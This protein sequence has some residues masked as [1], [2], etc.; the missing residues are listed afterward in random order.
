METLRFEDCRA[1][2]AASPLPVWVLDPEIPAFHWANDAALELWRATSVE[3]LRARDI[4]SQAPPKVTAR[5]ASAVSR[6]R[7]G[8]RIREEWVFYPKGEPVVMTLELR[9]ITL[10]DERFAVLNYALPM[11]ELT[12]E[13]QR[14]ITM[15]RHLA[16]VCALVSATGEVLSCNPAAQECFEDTKAW[17]PWFVEPALGEQLLRDALAEGPAEVLA[18]VETK[19]GRRW[20]AIQ[21]QHLR[22][23]VTG[24]ISVLVEHRDETERIEVQRLAADRGLHIDEL[25]TALDLVEAQRAEI[26]ELSAPILDV[27]NGTLAVPIIGRFE[28]AQRDAL[29]ERLLTAAAARSIRRVILD[30]TGVV[31]IDD[32]SARGLEALVRALRLLGTEP[33]VTGVRASLA[34]TLVDSR[35]D[36]V[37]VETLRSLAVALSRR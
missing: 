1:G 30:L 36:F 23:P 14:E 32:A 11:V 12:Q 31:E 37:E 10:D 19:Q 22:D 4:V 27:G 33:V 3:E 35:S 6:V 26:L 9:A 2:L 34:R 17:L 29:S 16:M 8:Q 18:E 28:L 5:L 21:A 15:A 24:D 25:R 20:H 7:A 13:L